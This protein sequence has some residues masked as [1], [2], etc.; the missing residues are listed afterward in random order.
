[1]P[2]SRDLFR[3]EGNRRCLIGGYKCQ[4]CGPTTPKARRRLRREVR[5]VLRQRF[6]IDAIKETK[7]SDA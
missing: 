6:K 2:S 1:M 5:R 4:C 7:E 3:N